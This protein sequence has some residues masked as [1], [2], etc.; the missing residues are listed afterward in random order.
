MIDTL[1]Q[2]GNFIQVWEWLFIIY[3]VSLAASYLL[4]DVIALVSLSRYLPEH[5]LDRLPEGY[6]GF[7]PGISLLAPA[8]NEEA[9]IAGSI[10]SLLQLT[11]AEYE[12]IVIND[13]SPDRTLDVL[14]R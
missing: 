10:R 4:L 3:F 14:M 5:T 13:G 1:R 12:I 8:Y 9:T 7:E 11:Y 2:A 6:T